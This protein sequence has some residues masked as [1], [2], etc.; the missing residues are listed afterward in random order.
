M[1]TTRCFYT[2]LIPL[3][4]CFFYQA[5]AQNIEVGSRLDKDSLLIGAQTVLR[6]SAHI[7]TNSAI[8]F[9]QLRD[10]IG[11]IKIVNSLKP[12]TAFNKNDSSAETI[13]HSYTITSFDTGVYV[14]PEFELLTTAGTY[15]TGS[16][17]L[18]IISVPVDTTKAFYDIKQP[19]VVSYTFWDWLKDHWILVTLVLAGIL[20]TIALIIYLKNRPK[21]TIVKKVVVIL[22]A[23]EI[24][25]NKLNLLR[26]KKLWLQNEIK[27]HYSE[28]ADILHEYLEKR[29]K[30]QT[31]EQTTAEIL[32]ELK[33]KPMPAGSKISLEQLLSFIDL[34]KFA[35]EKPSPAESEQKMEAAA[36]FIRQTREGPPL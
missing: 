17:T 36:D 32:E 12:D 35:R 24:A 23:D 31:L 29:Y 18:R 15:K 11:K 6:I 16:V 3:L 5:T 34:V 14:I 27:L 9:P 33:D 22:T 4:I 26:D 21:V 1:R 13:T 25:L 2:V 28:L 10:S 19:F 20:A 30:I 8:S 7:P